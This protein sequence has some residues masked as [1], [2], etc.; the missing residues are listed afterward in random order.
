MSTGEIGRDCGPGKQCG[1][2]VFS[3]EVG[4]TDGGNYFWAQLLEAEVSTFH[5]GALA[6]ATSEIN[7][8]LKS[9]QESDKRRL[10]FLNTPFGTMLAWVNH[11]VAIPDD[12]V[13]GDSKKEDIANALRLL[14][15][16]KAE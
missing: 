15:L 4:C 5:D 7:A 10:S 12:A 13:T 9:I 1:Y 14:G 11:D 6:K 3:E 2:A 16:P 8:M